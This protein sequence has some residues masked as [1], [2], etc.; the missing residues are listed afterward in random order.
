MEDLL[1]LIIS[2]VALYW[3]GSIEAT[4]GILIIPFLSLQAIV[5]AGNLVTRCHSFSPRSNGQNPFTE[6]TLL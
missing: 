5:M 1:E 2:T 3:W 6:M 4:L